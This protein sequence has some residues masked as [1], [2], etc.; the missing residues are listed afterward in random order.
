[1]KS[2]FMKRF[3][4]FI[5]DI[6]FVYLLVSLI[7]GIKFLNPNYDKYT[8]SVNNYVNVFKDY[9]NN[10][11]SDKVFMEKSKDNLYLTTKYSL[12]NSIVTIVVLIGY[13]GVFQKFNKG[14][15]LGKKITKIKV[16][17]K[18]GKDLS[19]LKSILRVVPIYFIIIGNVI[20]LMVN[21]I[22]VYI[23]DKDAFFIVNSVFVYIV[24]FINIISIVMMIKGEQKR[25]I[26]DYL[27]GSKVIM[28]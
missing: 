13:F 14:Q 24:L 2:L 10:E 9:T 28:E 16:V 18:E 3:G 26:H 19:L 7:T 23:L 1:M 4:A 27:A 6:I 12:S 17:D 25:G 21:S 15:T 22:F 11:I 5:L 8:E 20:S